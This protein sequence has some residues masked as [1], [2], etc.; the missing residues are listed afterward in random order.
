MKRLATLLVA[1][2]LS[3][4]SLASH[5]ADTR[6]YELRIYVT[7]PGKLPDLLKRFREHTC[8]LFEKHGMENIGYWVPVEEAQGS[9]NTLIYFIAH[10]SR[11]A[12]KASWAGFIADPD[13]KAAAKASE[14]AGKILAQKPES[15]FCAATD[16]SPELKLGAASPERTFELRTYICPDA[17]KRTALLSRFRDHT[18][19][20]F[21][22]HGMT[23]VLYTTPTDAE[24]GAD[25]KLIYVLAHASKE[26]GLA[27]FQAFRAD[28]EWVAARAASETAAGGSLTITPMAAGVQS[29]YLKPTDF[30]PLR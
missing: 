13:W 19:K 11:D 22:K 10:K 23:N 26:A 4:L 25:T 12:A 9:Q 2:L 16:F 7:N 14:A 18:C 20:L 5:A 15:I 28:A 6:S 27:S 24:Q 30:S 21:A 8:K 17:A 1:S 29:I 3:F